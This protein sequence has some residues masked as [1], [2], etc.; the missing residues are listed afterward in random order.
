MA[1]VKG[2]TR[3]RNG[4]RKQVAAREPF[5]A[6]YGGDVGKPACLNALMG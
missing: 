1:R 5:K 3:V 6:I 2:L 4:L